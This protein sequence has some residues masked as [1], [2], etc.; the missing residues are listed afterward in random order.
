MWIASVLFYCWLGMDGQAE[1]DEDRPVR[2]DGSAVVYQHPTELDCKQ[3][4]LRA[5]VRSASMGGL[6]IVTFTAHCEQVEGGA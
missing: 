4:M 5:A 2:A 1:C 6:P 3:A